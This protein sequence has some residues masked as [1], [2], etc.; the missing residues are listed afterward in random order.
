MGEN[1]DT[2][3]GEIISILDSVGEIISILNGR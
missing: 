1:I 3:Y 2:Q